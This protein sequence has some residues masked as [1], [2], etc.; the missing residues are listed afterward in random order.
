MLAVCNSFTRSFA[1][2]KASICTQVVYGHFKEH[3]GFNDDDIKEIA[4]FGRGK[5]PG[6]ECGALY[7][8]RTLSKPRHASKIEQEFREAAGHTQCKKIRQLGR[9][10]CGGC[11][12]L[13]IELI[14]KY[15]GK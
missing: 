6:G 9:M 14:K 3:K 8:A 13:G 1:K 7:A 15:D 5:A 2:A 4:K 12:A 11:K 10:D